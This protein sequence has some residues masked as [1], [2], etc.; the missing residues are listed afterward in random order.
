MGAANADLR[1]FAA[2]QRGEKKEVVQE[3]NMA[4]GLASSEWDEKHAPTV[5][6]M[7]E[8]KI[9]AEFPTALAVARVGTS[10]R[11]R[12]SGWTLSAPDPETTELIEEELK[13]L[14]AISGVEPLLTFSS[15][16]P[17]LAALKRMAAAVG[18]DLLFVYTDETVVEGYFNPF[19]WGYFTGVGLFCIPGN[20]VQATGAVQ[21]VLIDVKSGFPLGVVTAKKKMNV[22]AIAAINYGEKKQT[23]G[24]LVQAECDKEM[25]RR[26][27][28]KIAS[29]VAAV[30]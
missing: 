1:G 14:K 13:D 12:M 22:A 7:P 17:S 10:D 4:F 21:G 18:A 9:L 30:K 6:E 19:G 15:S 5:G 29:V 16:E 24:R 11:E 26:L 8:R 23:S 28:R 2:S 3:L 20:T 27:A 25:A